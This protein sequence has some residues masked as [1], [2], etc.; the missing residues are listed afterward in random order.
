MEQFSLFAGPIS[1]RFDNTVISD[2]ICLKLY[3]YPKQ[4]IHMLS[5][6]LLCCKIATYI[7]EITNTALFGLEVVSGGCAYRL[8]IHKAQAS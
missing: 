1:N 5:S 3:L 6:Y 8:S 2:K 7:H 4:M